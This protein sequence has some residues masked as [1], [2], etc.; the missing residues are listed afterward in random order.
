MTFK[1]TETNPDKGTETISIDFGIIFT[2]F[3]FTETNPD[4]GTETKLSFTVPPAITLFT[5]TNPD[6]GTETV[7]MLLMLTQVAVYRN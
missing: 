6:K 5:E 2:F 1:F 4:K 7:G 3:M